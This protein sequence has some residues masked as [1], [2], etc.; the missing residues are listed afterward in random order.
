MANLI[1]ALPGV[2]M[3]VGEVLDRIA[4][5][6]AGGESGSPSEFRASQ[7]NVVLHFGF[8][9]SAED[10][11]ARFNAL[12]RFAQRYPSRIIVLCPKSP[13]GGEAMDAKLFSQCYIGESH[14]EMCCCEA[15][16]LSFNPDDCGHLANQ[17]SVWLEPD[18]PVYHWFSQVPPKRIRAY[19]NNL[20]PGVRRT[21]YDSSVEGGTLDDL[22][23]P[24]PDRVRDLAQARLL[25]VRQALGQFLSAYPPGQLVEGLREVTVRHEQGLTGEGM[26]L[27]EWVRGS[28]EACARNAKTAAFETVF[29]REELPEAAAAT[30]GAPLQQTKSGTKGSARQ[31]QP[32][33]LKR[34]ESG[35]ASVAKALEMDWEY[36][37]G[38][39]FHWQK[40]KCGEVGEIRA[41]LGAA[42]EVIPTR[43]KALPPEQELAEALFF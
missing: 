12:L 32:A 2:G 14:R 9:V 7:M 8:P 41:H 40:F 25:P 15:L 13:G 18:L 34:K 4:T 22:E 35:E 29:G 43:T 21:I 33:N 26:R 20:L 5:M 23:W 30:S 6:W 27:L 31:A 11:R 10:A 17:V 28:L 19:F 16:L 1:D 39:Y 38:R 24:E 37:D 36:E 3:P 42:E